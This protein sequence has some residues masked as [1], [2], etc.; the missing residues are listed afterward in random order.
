MKLCVLGRERNTGGEWDL[1]TMASIT[2]C[3]ST[4]SWLLTIVQGATVVRILPGAPSLEMM[5]S[6]YGAPPSYEATT[7]NNQSPTIPEI[8]TDVHVAQEEPPTTTDLISLASEEEEED[9]TPQA[10]RDDTESPRHSQPETTAGPA[11]HSAETG[12]QSPTVDDSHITSLEGLTWGG[13]SA[14]LLAVPPQGDEGLKSNS[15]SSNTSLEET[16]FHANVTPSRSDSMEVT[17]WNVTHSLRLRDEELPAEFTSTLENIGEK[18]EEE[19]E[20]GEEEEKE[21]ERKSAQIGGGATIAATSE[22]TQGKIL[23]DSLDRLTFDTTFPTEQPSSSSA[24]ITNTAAPSGAMDWWAE[25]F[26]ETQNITEDFDALVQKMEEGDTASAGSKSSTDASK[27]ALADLATACLSPCTRHEEQSEGVQGKEERGAAVMD[28]PPSSPHSPTL[29]AAKSDSSI[30]SP[31]ESS[32]K[33]LGQQPHSHSR[34]EQSLR[35]AA[36][37]SSRRDGG[38]GLRRLS[39][40]KNQSAASSTESLN[41]RRKSGVCLSAWLT[42]MVHLSEAY[43]FV[44]SISLSSRRVNSKVCLQIVHLLTIC[45]SV[46]VQDPARAPGHPPLV[47]N[48][49]VPPSELREH[50]WCRQGD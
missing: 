32:A 31:E 6:T 15:G 2:F 36:G 21:G 5:S 8:P 38:W 7:T 47:S 42:T 35:E 28:F 26:A 27:Q 18:E 50:T 34:S 10:N 22:Q 39:G 48:A 43:I 41:G 25:A 4:C 17:E 23:E 3:T 29:K 45:P 33:S 13:D 46:S 37:D 49:T 20:E 12:R 9:A 19:E 1:A 16:N 44:Y 11:L 40:Q 30:A 24:T 14:D